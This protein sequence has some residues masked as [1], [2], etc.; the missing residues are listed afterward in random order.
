MPQKKPR[1]SFTVTHR[2]A[3]H[4][5][6]AD[7]N[8]NAGAAWINSLPLGKQAGA[9]KATAAQ[10]FKKMIKTPAAAAYMAAEMAKTIAEIKLDEEAVLAEWKNLAMF[11]PADF[12]NELGAYKNI[13]EIPPQ[14]RKAISSIEMDILSNGKATIKKITF[15]SRT[16]A[17]DS[18]AKHFAMFREVHEHR[19]TWMDGAS[20]TEKLERRRYIEMEL[21]KRGV[22][23]EPIEGEVVSEPI[24]GADGVS[25]ALEAVVGTPGAG[26]GD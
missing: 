2:L 1:P 11:D 9:T 25:G 22:V 12:Y 4:Y 18:I 6:L 20:A 15:E 17:L 8:R 26:T 16:K 19:I 10:Q 7:P 5:Y 3:I 13:H 21:A 14:A 24:E 23:L